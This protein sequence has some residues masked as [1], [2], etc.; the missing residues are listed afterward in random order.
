MAFWLSAGDFTTESKIATGTTSNPLSAFRY[1]TL[2]CTSNTTPAGI[3]CCACESMSTLVSAK[4]A[5][6]CTPVLPP[7]ANSTPVL[8]W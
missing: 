5:R 2:R 7:L 1:S 8:T 6:P 3:V 4:V